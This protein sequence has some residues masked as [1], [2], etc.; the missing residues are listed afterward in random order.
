MTQ[1]EGQAFNQALQQYQLPLQ[2][3]AALKGTQPVSPVFGATPAA[4]VQ[5]PNYQ[6]AAQ[7]DFQNR[8]G[9]FQNTM[10]G[11]G[12]LAGGFGNIAGM[13]L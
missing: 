1:N 10:A 3:I 7:N 11:V 5:P 13:F 2:T 6:A 8:Q 4:Q 9:Q 12:Q